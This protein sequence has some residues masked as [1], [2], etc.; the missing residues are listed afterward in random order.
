MLD[1]ERLWQH[2]YTA[3]Q[4]FGYT[5]PQTPPPAKEMEKIRSVMND[6]DKFGAMDAAK[7]ISSLKIKKEKG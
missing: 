7:L 6:A 2:I 4:K 1:D 3:A 5:L